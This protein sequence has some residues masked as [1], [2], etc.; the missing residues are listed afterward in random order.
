MAGIGQG[1]SLLDQNGNPITFN[2][3][4]NVYVQLGNGTGIPVTNAAPLP[5]SEEIIGTQVAASA[6]GAA[7][8][9]V[10][11]SLPGAA[12]K[13]TY[14]RGFC[15]STTNPASVVSGIV[16]IANTVGGTLSFEFVENTTQGGLLTISFG[17]AGLAAN[18]QNTAITVQ[19]PAIAS[20]GAGAVSVWGVQ[21]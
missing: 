19:L 3:P 4:L 14:I 17:N 7:A 9:A 2:N 13:I 12:N 5:V 11:A 18:A 10:S 8:A 16:T 20:G 6:T 1:F 21:I 15:I